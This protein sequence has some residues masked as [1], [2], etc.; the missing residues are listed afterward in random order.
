MSAGRPFVNIIREAVVDTGLEAVAIVA[1][2]DVWSA[3][4]CK[5]V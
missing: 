4:R 2:D 5:R 3:L 1:V